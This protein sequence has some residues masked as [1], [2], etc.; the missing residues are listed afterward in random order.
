M[1]EPQKDFPWTF[2]CHKQLSLEM[3][4]VFG[5]RKRRSSRCLA[6]CEGLSVNRIFLRMSTYLCPLM[7][8]ASLWWTE[9]SEPRVWLLNSRFIWN[10]I[11]WSSRITNSLIRQFAKSSQARKHSNFPHPCIKY[12]CLCASRLARGICM[13]S[14]NSYVF[15][16][17]A[18]NWASVM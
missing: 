6:R 4:F 1:I 11:N 2:A 17:A 14:L 3:S 18:S 7:R 13:F 5:F 9:K 15:S 10:S 16:F 12:D 8:S